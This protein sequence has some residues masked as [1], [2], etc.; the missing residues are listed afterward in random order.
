MA[1]WNRMP[2]KMVSGVGRG[3]VYLMGVVIVKGKGQIWGWI[4]GVPLQPIRTFLH[5]CA[6]ATRS[7]Q[8]TFGTT[9]WLPIFYLQRAKLQYFCQ[10]MLTTIIFVQ[11]TV[12]PNTQTHRHTDR[13]EQQT[14]F[15][16]RLQAMVNIGDFRWV[17]ATLS[18]I[19][20]T[21][22]VV[23]LPYEPTSHPEMVGDIACDLELWH[24]KNSFCAFLATVKAY[25]HTKNY[26]CTFTG[27]HLRAVTDADNAGRHSTTTRVTYR[28][29][30]CDW[31]NEEAN[32]MRDHNRSPMIIVLFRSKR[33]PRYPK[34]KEKSM[35]LIMNEDDRSPACELLME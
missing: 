23:L 30:T 8:I 7:S 13:T 1:Y 29:S 10:Y 21:A 33:S 15:V 18:N 31:M 12:V 17:Y 5:N 34:S 9:C 3:W 6:R 16:D 19:L 11:L 22:M 32:P 4:L 25:T 24:I 2:F 20:G 26:T 35:K 14:A 27:S 28:Q